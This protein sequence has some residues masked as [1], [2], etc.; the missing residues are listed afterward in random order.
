MKSD[1]CKAQH[2]MFLLPLLLHPEDVPPAREPPL[3]AHH[4]LKGGRSF[5]EDTQE[6]VLDQSQVNKERERVQTAAEVILRREGGPR[7][8]KFAMLE[9]RSSQIERCEPPADRLLAV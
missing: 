4:R 2:D 1:L 5:A 9:E 7:V 8:F 3:E 6:I